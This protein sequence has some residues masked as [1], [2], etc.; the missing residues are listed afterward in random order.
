MPE[1]TSVA[2]LLMW[3]ASGGGAAI[4]V[5]RVVSLLLEDTSWWHKL[6]PF[7]KRWSIRVVAVLF[8]ILAEALL[9]VDLS[10]ILGA[11]APLFGTLILAL[12]NWLASQSQYARI[13]GS[14]YGEKAKAPTL[15]P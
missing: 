1:F 11:Y 14:R 5:G 8:G 9:E 10:P 15:G 4:I 12:W 6:S 3:I 2:E 7:V 13:M